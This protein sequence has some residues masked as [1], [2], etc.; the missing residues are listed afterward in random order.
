MARV[1]SLLGLLVAVLTGALFAEYRSAHL[2]SAAVSLSAPQRAPAAPAGLPARQAVHRQEWVAT[3]LA[4]PLFSPVRRPA[5][6]SAGGASGPGDLARLTGVLVS[7]SEKH[8]I[9]AAEGGKPIVADE[10]T[11]IGAYVVRTIEPG[12]VTVAGPT[13]ERVLQPTYD[14]KAREAGQPASPPRPVP[15]RTLPQ[16]PGPPRVSP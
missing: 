15:P 1:A 3:I 7:R 4:R 13:G 9:F 12:Q 11:R 2:E 10:G 16:T 5:P 6:T 8:A 14:P